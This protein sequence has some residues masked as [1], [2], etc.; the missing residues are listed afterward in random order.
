MSILADRNNFI[1]GKSKMPTDP[2]LNDNYPCHSFSSFGSKNWFFPDMILDHSNIF[3][4]RALYHFD[5][6]L[7]CV[8]VWVS[9]WL[10]K[11]K[12][13][14]RVAADCVFV[15]SRTAL[16]LFSNRGNRRIGLYSMKIIGIVWSYAPLSLI[17]P[18]HRYYRR[19]MMT[20]TP[21][22]ADLRS[23]GRSRNTQRRTTT[24]TT[25]KAPS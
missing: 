18:H 16:F 12:R 6:L 3:F 24:T 9:D 13:A 25:R 21:P 8:L 14:S 1:Q 10:S 7:W 15:P 2:S 5:L 11:Y 19:M 23:I 4:F 22:R 17:H 20:T